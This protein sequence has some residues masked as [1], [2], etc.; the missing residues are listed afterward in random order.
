MLLVAWGCS[1]D[2]A[3]S[4]QNAA[5]ET[6]VMSGM[7][8]AESPRTA[9]APAPPQT[10]SDKPVKLIK[11]GN[12]TL[13]V[14]DIA[15]AK[16]QVDQLLARHNGYYENEQLDH[17]D[18]RSTA[19]LDIRIPTARFDSLLMQ[20]DAGIGTLLNRQI[21][22]QDVGEEYVDIQMRL[23]NNLAYLAQYNQILK[24]AKT[25]KEILEVQEIIRQIEEEIESRKGRLQYLDNQVGY[26]T[27][28]VTLVEPSSG[29]LN[30][31][32]GWGSRLVQAFRSGFEGFLQAVVGVVYLW[33]FWLLLAL[34]W[35]FWRRR[36]R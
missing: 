8:D 33:P 27:L 3:G 4:E 25:I 24:Q 13:E 26:A 2:S 36:K 29:T 34:G 28:S 1:S 7:A 35:V 17:A 14:E 31:H 15:T 16:R 20:L 11:R 10:G 18:G 9:E 32:P 6:I 23:E 21:S 22:A 12:M 19:A 5:D 30:S